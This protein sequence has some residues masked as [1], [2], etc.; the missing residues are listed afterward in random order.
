MVTSRSGLANWGSD[1]D[2]W[3][4]FAMSQVSSALTLLLIR[5][6]SKYLTPEERAA[7]MLLMAAVAALPERIHSGTAAA[8]LE[9]PDASQMFKQ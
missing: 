9:V 7:V 5:F 4:M 1:M 6:G 2:F 8:M 3:Q